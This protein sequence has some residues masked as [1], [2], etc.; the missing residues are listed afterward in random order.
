MKDKPEVVFAVYR[1]KKGKAKVLEGLARKHSPL[2]RRLGLITRR[3]TILVRAK[4]GTLFEVFEW[5]SAK[6]ARLA[7]EHPAVAK[8]WETMGTH[9]QFLPLKDL[10]EAAC[11]FAHF[12]PLA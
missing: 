5:K 9:G 10:S 12:S 11:P 8:V 6:S 2:L 3:P 7:H 1:P 4:D